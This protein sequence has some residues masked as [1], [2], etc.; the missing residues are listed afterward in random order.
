MKNL[1]KIGSLF[2]IAGGI[3]Y[4][5]KKVFMDENFKYRKDEYSGIHIT[6]ENFKY[7]SGE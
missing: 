3:L 4:K 1:F 6:T 5:G 2:G 7:E